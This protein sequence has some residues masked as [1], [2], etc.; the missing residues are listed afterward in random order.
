MAKKNTAEGLA[1]KIRTDKLLR[2]RT[3]SRLTDALQELG[4]KREDMTLIP[5][6]DE[7][8]GGGTQIVIISTSDS[9]KNTRSIII[10]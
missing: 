5:P 1:A 10:W 7:P 8:G 4:I 9:K 2:A 3:V 6:I